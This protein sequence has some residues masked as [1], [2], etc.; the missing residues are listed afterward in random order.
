M[1]WGVFAVIKRV[2]SSFKEGFFSSSI[3]GLFCVMEEE[4]EVEVV[5]VVEKTTG[6]VCAGSNHSKKS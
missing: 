1:I 5:T 3:H 6:G 4:E 2:F